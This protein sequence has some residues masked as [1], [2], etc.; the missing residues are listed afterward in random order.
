MKLRFQTKSIVPAFGVSRRA[1]LTALPRVAIVALAVAVGASLPAA[2]QTGDAAQLDAKSWELYRAGK[3]SEA[4]PL[5]Q[6]ALAIWE[7][8]LGPEHPN[9]APALNRLAN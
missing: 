6:Q 1:R 3:Y 9:V 8:T 7:K 5:A 4:A 2:A